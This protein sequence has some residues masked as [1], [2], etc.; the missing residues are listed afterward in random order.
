VVEIEGKK[1]R[2]VCYWTHAA[3][4]G[5]PFRGVVLDLTG[6]DTKREI[7]RFTKKHA[8][9]LARLGEHFGS[10]PAIKWVCLPV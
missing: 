6:V 2:Q 3:V 9:M 4:S 7:E 5:P 10:Q 1:Y 8:T